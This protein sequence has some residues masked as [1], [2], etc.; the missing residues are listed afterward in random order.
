[1]IKELKLK[2]SSLVQGDFEINDLNL[3][4]VFQVNCP[5][6]FVHALPL[7]N[8]IK[9]SYE[10]KELNV[11]GLA[12]AFEDF[13]YNTEENVKLLIDQGKLVGETKRVLH[14][15]GFENL[16][17]PVDFPI[18]VDY[19]VEDA[20][21]FYS[22]EDARNICMSNP[23]FSH[24]GED[25]QEK[26]VSNVMRNLEGLGRSS[27]TF[28]VNLMRGTPTWVIFDKEMNILEHWFGHKDKDDVFQMLDR[29]LENVRK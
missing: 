10:E 12:T 14:E 13:E 21:K 18:A 17:Y 8:E 16:P 26:A 27:Y 24:L 3:L 29:H 19:F 9:H 20:R 15:N 23:E 25:D 7:A 5:G 28:T 4:L 22:R 6:C 11:L 1:M 2:T